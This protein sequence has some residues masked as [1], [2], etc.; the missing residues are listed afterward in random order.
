MNHPYILRVED[1]RVEPMAFRAER[2]VVR[3]AVD[4]D[5][6]RKAISVPGTPF[7]TG[8]EAETAP[9]VASHTA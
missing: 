7:W 8:L 6:S 3:E 9:P 1:I 5:L 2:V 4:G